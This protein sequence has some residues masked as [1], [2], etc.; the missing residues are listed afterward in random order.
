MHAIVTTDNPL[1]LPEGRFRTKLMIELGATFEFKVLDFSAGVAQSDYCAQF[2]G[3]GFVVWDLKTMDPS[4]PYYQIMF[5]PCD[6]VDITKKDNKWRY[7]FMN[8]NAKSNKTKSF[9]FILPP[10]DPRLE[11]LS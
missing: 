3:E 5:L 9:D 8:S 10:V 6:V 2:L 4:A 1:N 7:E 11:K